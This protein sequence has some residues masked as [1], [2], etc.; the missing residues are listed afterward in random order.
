MTSFKKSMAWILSLAMLL[1]S[2][3]I[4]AFATGGEASE[5]LTFTLNELDYKTGAIGG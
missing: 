5:T 2:L 4:P 1:S 3:Y